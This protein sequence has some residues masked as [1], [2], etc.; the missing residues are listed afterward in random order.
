[1]SN[2]E[3]ILQALQ[4]TVIASST[5]QIKNAEAQLRTFENSTSF[6]ED[7]ALILE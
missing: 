1:M 3:N 2:A 6:V 7:I 5:E 4:H